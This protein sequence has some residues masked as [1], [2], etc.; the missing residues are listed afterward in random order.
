MGAIEYAFPQLIRVYILV[1]PSHLVLRIRNA[2]LHSTL[3]YMKR[4]MLLLRKD[5]I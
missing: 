4:D 2:Y 3:C 1:C 5:C